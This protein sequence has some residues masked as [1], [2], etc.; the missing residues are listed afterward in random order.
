MKPEYL[1][2]YVKAINKIEDYFEY[3]SK[4]N[5]D[6]DFVYGVLDRLVNDLQSL[7]KEDE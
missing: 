3:R 7:E 1:E 2:H 4:S 6:T 5:K